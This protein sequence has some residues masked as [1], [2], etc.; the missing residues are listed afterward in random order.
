MSATA[1]PQQPT[2]LPATSWQG[3]VRRTLRELRDDHATDWAA[4]L[5]YYAVQAIFPALLVVVSLV[6]LAGRSTTDALLANVETTAPGPAR[7]IVTGA[8]E[9]LQDAGGAAGLGL[10]VGIAGALWSASGYVGAFTRA[11]NAI[12][13]VEEGRP[14]LRL[15]PQQLAVTAVLLVL[16]SAS[17]VA[18]VFTGGLAD[19]AADLLGIDPGVVSV[20]DVVKWPLLALV[21]T[22]ML[23]ILYWAAPNAEQ[24]GLRWVTPGG[25]AAVTTWIAASA[26]FAFY[27]ARFSSYDRTYGSLGAVIAFLVWLWITNLAVLFGAELNAELTRAKRMREGQPEDQEPIT[28]PRDTRAMDDE[29]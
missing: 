22:A 26:L 6:G 21:V 2:D 10:V 27:V 23:A 8:I 19:H 7:E 18:V 28:P 9:H 3:V 1:R 11:S 17:A 5:T 20:F 16:L 12:W 25:L 13:E 4:A 14:F 24:E 15:R 29:G